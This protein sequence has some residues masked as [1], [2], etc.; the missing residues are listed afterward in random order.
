MKNHNFSALESHFADFV[1]GLAGHPSPLLAL[2][3]RLVSRQVAEGHICLDLEEFSGR[4]VPLPTGEEAL[5]PQL[6][7]WLRELRNSGVVGS[8][9]QWQPLILDPPLLYLQR[10]WQYEHEVAAFIL[11]RS[12]MGPQVLDKD[13]LEKGILRMF[14]AADKAASNE[15]DWQREAARKTLA[16][17]FCVIS[18]GPGTG[19]TTTVARILALFHELN[20]DEERPVLLAAPTGKA[21]AR[22]QE[23]IRSAKSGLDC[24]PRVKAAIPETAVTLHRLLGSSAGGRRYHAGNRLPAR[25]V[26]VDEASMVDL[27]LMAWLMAALPE[28]CSLLLLG[29]HN[30][31]ASVQPGAVLGDICQ[32]LRD[33]GFSHMLAELKRTYRFS[34][35]SGI[36]ALSRAVNSGDGPG[37]LAV[38]QDDRFADARWVDI[39]E[40]MEQFRLRVLDRIREH[41]KRIVAASSPGEALNVMAEFAVL[42]ALRRGPWGVENINLLA[43]ELFAPPG[44]VYFHGYPVMVSRNQYELQLYNGDTGLIVRDPEAD[45]ELRAFFPG[46]TGIRRLLPARLPGHETAFAVTVHKSQGSEFDHVLL[47]LPRESSPVLSRELIYTAVTRAVKSVEVWGDEKIF[48]DAV[49]SPTRR[50]SGLVKALSGE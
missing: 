11:S 28:S 8:P 50:K 48:M 13:G 34:G 2:A 14:Q 42:S 4:P 36:G 16:S 19:K 35:A 33:G 12:R 43:T 41:H 31:L 25:L 21:A 6:D 24:A 7:F 26:V 23:A 10:Y 29:D 15:P 9:G 20:P 5:C 49:G 17:R 47:I 44:S 1:L 39:G 27:P 38:L 45:D 22:L 30:Q 46:A 3:A 37:A 32:G 18:G 40:D